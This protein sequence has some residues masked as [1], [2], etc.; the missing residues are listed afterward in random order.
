MVDLTIFGND[1][2][3]ILEYLESQQIYEDS[4]MIVKCSMDSLAESFSLSKHTVKGYL[5]YLC[6]NGYT[7]RINI[8]G[9]YVITDKGLEVLNQMHKGRDALKASKYSCCSLFAGVGGI[10]LGFAN[11]GFK[12]VYANE[13]DTKATKTYE[14]NFDLKVDTRDIHKVV[15]ELEI[16][17][18]PFNGHK[19]N[20]II[21]GF[22]CQAFSIAGYREGFE[23][24]QGRGGLFFEIMKIA[25]ITKPEVIF[26]ENVK[27]L[28]AHDHGKT[29]R[30]IQGALESEGYHIAKKVL[31]SMEYGNVPQNRERIY[32]VAFKDEKKKTDFEFPS[33]IK[34]TNQLHNVLDFEEKV[35]DRFYY[36]E[37]N[38]K[39]YEEI[40]DIINSENTVYQWRRVYVREN[41]SGV[42]PTLTAN[43]GTGGH[44]VPLIY[45]KNGIRKLTP[46]ECF[47][48]QGFPKNY[49]LPN[50]LAM[51][52]LYKQ[53]GNSVTVTVIERIAKQILKV[54]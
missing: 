41:K 35:P 10:D 52:Y 26:L 44:N 25:K 32:V 20:I 53:A 43:M 38:F 14:N 48:L 18:D 51:S 34:L 47:S 19:F 42:C 22:P 13:F 45:T 37:K 21:A 54:L 4:Q 27:N 6:E 1:L 8:K 3:K 16:G 5:D 30:I 50:D 15:E 2:F 23:D 49:D 39:R 24:K 11:A 29:F 46:Q 7:T 12:T 36:T 28:V 33:P 31:N 9:K 40:K 17:K